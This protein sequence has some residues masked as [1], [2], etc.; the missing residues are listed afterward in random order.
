[1]V[2]RRAAVPL[3]ITPK[4]TMQDNLKYALECVKATLAA[5]NPETATREELAEC[6]ARCNKGIEDAMNPIAPPTE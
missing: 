1:M 4:T 2:H 3:T 5:Y 6:F